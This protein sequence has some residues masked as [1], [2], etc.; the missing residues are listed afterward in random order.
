MLIARLIAARGYEVLVWDD[1]DNA[2]NCC[3]SVSWK[4]CPAAAISGFTRVTASGPLEQVTQVSD[5]EEDEEEEEEQ[6]WQQQ[7]RKGAAESCSF[8]TTHIYTHIYT[9]GG[10]RVDQGG[11]RG[12]RGVGGVRGGRGVDGG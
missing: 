5:P 1:C 7:I 9:H 6:A 8:S 2:Q 4:P 3:F 10:M 12:V 11:G